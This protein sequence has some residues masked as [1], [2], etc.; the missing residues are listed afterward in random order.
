MVQADCIIISLILGV[1]VGA[2][3]VTEDDA[4]EL[5]ENRRLVEEM[6]TQIQ[7]L[8]SENQELRVRLNVSSSATL[9]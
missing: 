6:K 1:T 2:G 5:A 4:Q 3:E 7:T 8:Q 9:T